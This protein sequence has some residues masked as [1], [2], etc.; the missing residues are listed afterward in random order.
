[1]EWY[2]SAMVGSENS[3]ESRIHSNQSSPTTSSHASL[4]MSEWQTPAD[5]REATKL[6]RSPQTD[7]DKETGEGMLTNVYG[8]TTQ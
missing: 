1:M 3:N 8:I 7:F 6:E 4:H 5:H 2:V